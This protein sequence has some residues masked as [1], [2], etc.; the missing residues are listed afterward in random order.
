MLYGYLIVDLQRKSKTNNNKKTISKN[1]EKIMFRAFICWLLICIILG[2]N[3]LLI[4]FNLVTLGLLLADIVMLYFAIKNQR[5]KKK[6]ENYE[7]NS[8]KIW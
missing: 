3:C 4:D 7:K 6:I 8:K 5:L 2:I 1:M